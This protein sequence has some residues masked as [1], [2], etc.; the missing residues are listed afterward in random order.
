MASKNK[1]IITTNHVDRREFDYTL[2]GVNL[3]FKLRT[4]VKSELQAFKTLM[5]LGIRDI[6]KE[7]DRLDGK[8]D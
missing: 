4:D 6:E 2:G 1:G 7:L 8:K 3:N 5:E